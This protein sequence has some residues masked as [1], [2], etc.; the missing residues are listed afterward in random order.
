M[1][2][3]EI[4]AGYLLWPVSL[5]NCLQWQEVIILSFLFLIAAICYTGRC[6]IV[7]A[8]KAGFKILPEIFFLKAV[9]LVFG[10]ERVR[11]PIDF[12]PYL[13][14]LYFSIKSSFYGCIAFLLVKM[15]LDSPWIHTLSMNLP[16]KHDMVLFL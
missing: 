12:V 1:P 11:N 3:L 2:V 13:F 6:T 14:W 9:K 4:I 16:L 7:G 10:R 15:W 5:S 8:E